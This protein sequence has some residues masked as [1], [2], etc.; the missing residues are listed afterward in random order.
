MGAH[1]TRHMVRC[2]QAIHEGSSNNGKL[3]QAK[4]LKRKNTYKPNQKDTTFHFKF[5]M[6]ING[7]L[8]YKLMT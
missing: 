4:P 5:S 1:R 2:C 6:R 3:K 7:N 8:I